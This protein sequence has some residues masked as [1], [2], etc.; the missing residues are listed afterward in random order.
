MVN[1]SKDQKGFRFYY[2]S[3]A[4]HRIIVENELKISHQVQRAVILFSFVCISKNQT[5]ALLY[6]LFEFINISI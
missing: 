2:N 3:G 1:E 4:A 5:G 6:S